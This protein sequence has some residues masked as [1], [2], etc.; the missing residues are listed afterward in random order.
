LTKPAPPEC[1]L[2]R[3]LAE[4]EREREALQG[5]LRGAASELEHIVATDCSENAKDEAL[6]A[7]TRLRRAASF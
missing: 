5:M 4:A 2:R 6:D 1:E 7:A 3:K